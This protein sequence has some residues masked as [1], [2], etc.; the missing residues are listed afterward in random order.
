MTEEHYRH[1]EYIY[2]IAPINQY[3]Q[4]TLK[5]EHQKS[6]VSIEIR[7]DFYHTARAMHGSVYFKALDDAAYFA[8]QS[9]ETEYFILTSDFRIDF[10]RPA[11]SGQITAIEKVMHRGRRD[12]LCDAELRNHKGQLLGKGTGRF[13]KSSILLSSFP[14]QPEINNT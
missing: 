10:I 14:S 6:S 8:A 1:L 13:A 4:P 5:V 11:I 2:S 3:F 9:I 7:E 12:I